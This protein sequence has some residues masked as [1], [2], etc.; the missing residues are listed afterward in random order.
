MVLVFFV[1]LVGFWYGVCCDFW[2]Y[3][4]NGDRLD[5]DCFVCDLC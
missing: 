5:F 1:L 4:I 3:L 2:V